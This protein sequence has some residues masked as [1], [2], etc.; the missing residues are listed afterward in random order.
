MASGESDTRIAAASTWARTAQ[1][2]RLTP[3]LAADAITQGV[4]NNAFKLN[5]IAESLGYVATDPVAASS[6]ARAA[7]LA[8]A[9][10]LPV[11]PTASTST[12]NSGPS[13]NAIPPAIAALAA[14]SAR[15]KLAEAARL[16]TQVA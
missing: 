2:G 4:T 12:A 3:T 5:R 7:M 13:A 14:S 9:A 15:T 8:T 16:L 6:V 1:D 10:L 11:K